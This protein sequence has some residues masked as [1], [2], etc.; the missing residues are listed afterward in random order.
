[1]KPSVIQ[2]SDDEGGLVAT[3]PEPIANLDGTGATAQDKNATVDPNFI[4]I[5]H[6]A[7]K[8]APEMPFEPTSSHRFPVRS[9]SHLEIYDASPLEQRSSKRRRTTEEV[10]SPPARVSRRKTEITYG[11]SRRSHLHDPGSPVKLN[12][13][14]SSEK[15]H[16]EAKLDIEDAMATSPVAR[17]Q[18]PEPQ[19]HNPST[20]TTI[21]AGSLTQKRLLEEALASKDLSM[22]PKEDLDGPNGLRYETNIS[23]ILWPASESDLTSRRRSASASISNETPNKKNA[24]LS[25]SGRSGS[26]EFPGIS[27]ESAHNNSD[28]DISTESA[29]HQSHCSD[30][31]QVTEAKPNDQSAGQLHSNPKTSSSAGY[32]DDLALPM[33]EK[34]SASHFDGVGNARREETGSGDPTTCNVSKVNS[35]QLTSDEIAIG[36]PREQYKPRPSRSRSAR[37]EEDVL[38]LSISPKRAARAKRKKKSDA[39]A[40]KAAD[41]FVTAEKLATIT[42]MGFS[43]SQAERA[44]R[45]LKGD[46][47]QAVDRL[48]NQQIGD[49]N[50]GSEQKQ[51]PDD[52]VIE[53]TTAHAL[54]FG[55]T[56]KERSTNDETLVDKTNSPRAVNVAS[57]DTSVSADAPSA[58]G[59]KSLL[60]VEIIPSKETELRESSPLAK[61]KPKKAK[62][63]KT[64][65][66]DEKETQLAARASDL[67][68]EEGGSPVVSL[69]KR[70]AT[71]TDVRVDH[72]VNEQ[73]LKA[74]SNQDSAPVAKKPG[75]GRPKKIR[76]QPPERDMEPDVRAPEENVVAVDDHLK[77][78]PSNTIPSH[79]ERF[80]DEGV[81]VKST[82]EKQVPHGDSPV[83]SEPISGDV[84]TPHKDKPNLSHKQHSPINKGKVAYRVGLSRRARIA[85]LL[86]MVKK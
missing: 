15:L 75:R 73:P 19:D 61:K 8:S 63:Q 11:S 71:N 39:V 33:V 4:T 12:D 58:A 52:S 42:S 53:Q 21:P 51:H 78:I 45:A 23:S 7:I 74:M 79:V 10:V 3:P 22:P 30:G 56:P 14:A 84:T 67:E 60:R 29:P 9:S 2:D 57:V 44:L 32:S 13:R 26:T 37:V 69:G 27:E 6:Q 16:F 36:L 18:D 50:E 5:G 48:C 72:K 20:S 35:D 66:P 47:E 17:S 24:F 68:A 49:T 31:A 43:P 46:V 55:A 76:E 81:S 70:T 41:P 80:E 64:A 85:P 86:R 54:D 38:D 82:P 77:E 28:Q 1:M 65:H 59:G 83:R 34:Q 40:E 25:V 62:R